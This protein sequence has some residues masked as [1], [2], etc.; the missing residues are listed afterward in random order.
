MEQLKVLI[1]TDFGVLPAYAYQLVR[2]LGEQVA[3]EV[4]F[5]HV[6]QVPDTVTMDEQG[7]IQT[8]GEIDP[9]F[10]LA[11]KQIAERQLDQLRAHY[12]QGVA[13]ALVLGKVTDAITDFASKGAFDMIV[14]G[15]KGAWSWK[16]RLVGSETQMVARHAGIPVLSLMCDRSQFTLR[17]ILLVHD[18]AHPVHAPLPLLPRLI[19][20]FGIHVHLFQLLPAGGE[21]LRAQTLAHMHAFAQ[22]HGISAYTCH[23]GQDKDVAHGVSHFGHLDEMDLVCIGTHGKGGLMHSSATETL[24][25]QLKKPILSFHLPQ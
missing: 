6:L 10:V 2:R 3:L 7:R 20:S 14:M 24:I 12:G 15:T 4:C 23:L 8:C 1:P 21:G 17:H 9:D 16:E 19:Q 18:F 25:Q 13:V 11:Q 5:L 22:A